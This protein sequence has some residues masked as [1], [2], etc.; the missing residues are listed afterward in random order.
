[1]TAKRPRQAIIYCRI[2]DD[3]EG[4]EYGV[5][6]QEAHCRRL[7]ERRGWS[8]VAVLVDNDITG[9]GRR[10]R[11]G[12]DRLLT[13]LQE[14]AA[15]A[16]LAV[17]DKRLNR[18][19]RNAFALLDLIQEQDIAVEFTKGGPINMNT[20]EG[21]GIARRKA[22]DAQEESEEIGERVADA[23]KD[24]VRDGT[25]RGGGRPFGYEA[26]GI[27][28]RSLICPDC[29]ATEGF[30]ITPVRDD[31]IIQAVTV[32]CPNGCDAAP[33]NTPGSEAWHLEAATRAIAD[34]AT[35]RSELRKWHAAGVRT[36]ARRKRLPD[37][38]RTE[39]MPGDWTETTFLKL[40]L[41]PRNAG[42]MEVGGEIVGKGAWPALVDEETW[43]IC[44]AVLKN[45]ARRTS[46]GPT[47]K[48]LGGGTYL[49]GVCREAVTTTGRGR[50]RNGSSYTCGTG[51]HVSRNAAAVDDHVESTLLAQFVWE[52]VRDPFWPPAPEAPDAQSAEELNVR[53]AG[54]TARLKGLAD[55][56]ADD[57]DADPVE[58][59]SAARRIKEKI[60]AVEREMAETVAV[61]A[62]AG[63]GA[64]DDI[65][66]PELV[67]RHK[68]DPDG[69]LAWWRDTYSLERRREI[70]A[71]LTVVT[72]LP[73]T[74]GR[75]AGWKPGS[76]YFNPESVYIDWTGAA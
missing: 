35:K 67:R 55:A 22:I 24:N 65:D 76:K 8:V 45:P 1:M 61:S 9:T 32:A 28:P 34:G 38:T 10:Q 11:P 58:Y 21:R 12:Y 75:T 68:A 73:A 44:R 29:G 50:S 46:P 74:S 7:A 40:L 62:A 23:K 59:R 53:H 2:S 3:R 25:Y 41:R 18:N 33:V 52:K 72:I 60:A 57:D 49:C 64:L 69:A 26:D 54:L 39:P 56:F 66:F 37:G 31:G 71:L 27:T 16:I 48:W 20:A 47:R 36:P 30:V 19:Y 6:R 13:M 5:D 17:S 70:I 4:R 14:G 63:R 42:L 43:R 15:N 51:Q